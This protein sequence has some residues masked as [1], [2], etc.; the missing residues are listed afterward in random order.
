MATT[1]PSPSKLDRLLVGN[2]IFVGRRM[3]Q[4]VARLAGWSAAGATGPRELGRG[5][6]AG[7]WLRLLPHQVVV[8]EDDG[9]E[10][11]V[12]I[13]EPKDP[14]QGMALAGLVVAALSALIM[15]IARP[16]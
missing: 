13:V 2:P 9:S 1:I 10:Y 5:G 6:G 14:T 12:D 3:L 8:Q 11:V 15:I 7:A 4:P 16:R